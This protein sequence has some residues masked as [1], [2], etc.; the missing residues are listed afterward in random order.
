MRIVLCQVWEWYGSEDMRQGRYK[1]KGGA[2]FIFD[3]T[4]ET[5]EMS[6]EDIIEKWNSTFMADDRAFKYEAKSVNY[7]W[8]PQHCEFVNNSFRIK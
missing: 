7:Y 1:A 4:E 2:E 5:Q 8:K 3:E 6:E